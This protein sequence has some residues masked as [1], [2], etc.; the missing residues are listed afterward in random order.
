M[1]RRSSMVRQGTARTSRREEAAQGTSVIDIGSSWTKIGVVGDASVRF[2]V[3]TPPKLREVMHCTRD[4]DSLGCQLYPF[5]TQCAC[6]VPEMLSTDKPSVVLVNVS[7][8]PIFVD[9]V[10]RWLHANSGRMAV[11]YNSQLAAITSFGASSGIVLDVGWFSSRSC[12]IVGGVVVHETI[13][14]APVGWSHVIRH[15]RTQ[16]VQTNECFSRGAL[17]QSFLEDETLSHFVRTFGV[18]AADSV[19]LPAGSD[20]Y[21]L[22]LK[23]VLI[24][25]SPSRALEVLFENAD[26]ERLTIPKLVTSAFKRTQHCASS[27]FLSGGPTLIP[28]F[29]RRLARELK[30]FEVVPTDFSVSFKTSCAAAVF[31]P[32]LGGLASQV[33]FS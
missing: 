30:K 23:S 19:E 5:L 4:E 20:S 16:F 25:A 2:C 29:P 33:A 22:Q 26:D 8:N 15:V 11:P 21:Q 18:V 17:D 24:S 6:R 13:S 31:A 3:A 10:L 14:V 27:L 32:V 28:N 9:A 1:T 12:L 7:Q